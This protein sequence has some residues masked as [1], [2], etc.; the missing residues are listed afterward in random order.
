M[1]V[2]KR[3]QQNAHSQNQPGFV[4]IPE[5]A[6]GRHHHVLLGARGQRQQDADAEIEPIKNN[7]GEDGQSHQRRENQRKIE[8]HRHS[9]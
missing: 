3:H 8:F 4:G 2:R 7:V 9:T 1:R 5:R 6:D